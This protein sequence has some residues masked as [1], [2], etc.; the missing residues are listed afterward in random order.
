MVVVPAK[1]AAPA[2]EKMPEKGGAALPAPAYMVVTL[3]AD[4]KLTVDDTLTTSTSGQRTFVTPPIDSDKVYYY[5]L[6]AETVR[7]G[8]TL[9]AT[10]RVAVQGGR[11]STITLDLQPAAVASR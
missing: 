10:Q 7:D 1:P 5:T 8:K 4:A 6:K 3:P 11:Q 9:T 2:P